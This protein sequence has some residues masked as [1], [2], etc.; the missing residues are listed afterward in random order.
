[1]RWERESDVQHD[2]REHLSAKHG[3]VV[4]PGEDPVVEHNYEHAMY[5]GAT[6]VH[7][8]LVLDHEREEYE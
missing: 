4:R 3:K 8:N 6:D 5:D 7:G 2:R 1:M